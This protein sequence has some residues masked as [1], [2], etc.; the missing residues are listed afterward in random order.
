MYSEISAV[1]KMTLA[2]YHNDINLY[3]GSFKSVKLQ[4]NSKDPM[5]YTDNA[6]VC[7]ISIQSKNELPPHGFKS[8]FTSLE[9]CWQMDKDASTYYANMVASGDWKAEVNKHSQI[10]ALITQISELKKEFNQAKALNNTF[11]PASASS[12]PGSNKFEQ[13]HLEK[14]DNKEEFN[15]IV[16]DGKTYY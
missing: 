9:R 15:M 5:A 3:F 8:E 2:L 4:I 10:I 14:V 7:D 12:G 1:K 6:F 16:K 13:W 11:T